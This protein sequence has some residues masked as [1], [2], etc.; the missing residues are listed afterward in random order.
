MSRFEKI[1]GVG[2]IIIASV[3]LPLSLPAAV[4][5]LNSPFVDSTPTDDVAMIHDPSDNTFIVYPDVLPP[6]DNEDGTASSNNV[7]V[8]ACAWN[9]TTGR[10]FI[11]LSPAR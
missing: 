4:E 6:C 9:T 10:S 5:T 8:S 2:T 11:V 3:S 1:V 7:P